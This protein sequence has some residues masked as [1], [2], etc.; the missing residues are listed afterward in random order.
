MQI[1]TVN[2]LKI[3]HRKKKKILKNCSSDFCAEALRESRVQSTR[4]SGDS[5]ALTLVCRLPASTPA[6][7]VKR[8]RGAFL[9]LIGLLGLIGQRLTEWQALFQNV[10]CGAA[11]PFD[12][13]DEKILSTT[14]HLRGAKH[15][16]LGRLNCADACLPPFLGRA[17]QLHYHSLPAM[18]GGCIAPDSRAA[19]LR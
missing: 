10:F 12:S 13:T 3:Q 4:F 7:T 1:N 9:G 16:T 11:P 17:F 19:Q 6:G 2:V 18:C 15:P 8:C 14:P 5:T